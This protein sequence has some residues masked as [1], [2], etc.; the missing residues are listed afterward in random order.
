MAATGIKKLKRS[1]LMH[2]LDS[3]FGGETPSWFLPIIQNVTLPEM[4]KAFFSSSSLDVTLERVA[5]LQQ[6]TC[7]IL[8]H[9]YLSTPTR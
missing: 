3:T 7:L 8:L 6:K 1:H 5:Q 9:L 4:I 2:L